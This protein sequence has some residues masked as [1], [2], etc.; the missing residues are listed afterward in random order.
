MICQIVIFDENQKFL[1]EAPLVME[2]TNVILSEKDLDTK[3]KDDT[4]F[5]DLTDKIWKKIFEN[6]EGKNR[7]LINNVL[8][9][10]FT[11]EYD[12]LAAIELNF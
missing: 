10:C 2:T 9:N 3:L 6:F 1:L 12:Y 5:D 4:F 11:D 8:V 7:E